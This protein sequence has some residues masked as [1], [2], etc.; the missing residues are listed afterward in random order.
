MVPQCGLLLNAAGPRTFGFEPPMCRSIAAG[1]GAIS[2]DRSCL[3]QLAGSRPPRYIAFVTDVQRT[4]LYDAVVAAPHDDAPRL[5]MADHLDRQG[6]PWG[7]FIRAQLAL[8]HAARRGAKDEAG[9]HRDEADHLRR[10]HGNEWM[11]GVDGLVNFCTFNRG[12][13][14]KVSADAQQYLA[15]AGELYRRAPIRYLVLS[16]VGDFLATILQNPHIGQLISLHIDNRSRKNPIGDA[17][18]IAIAQCPHLRGLKVL[19]VR[20]QNIGMMG[21]EALCASKQLH[22]L[23]YVN[24]WGNPVE[25]PTE[26]YGTDWATGGVDRNGAYLPPI[27]HELGT[28]YGE[29]PWLHAPSR[30]VSYPPLMEEL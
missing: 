13:V 26:G 17:G 27:G 15:H 20:K 9:R 14:E 18:L 7:T 10:Q 4:R 19:E 2:P 12:F 21:V 3:G 22:S 11:N 1:S 8:T 25:D 30:L 6:D 16:D 24:L 29:L 5:A 23:L 28:K